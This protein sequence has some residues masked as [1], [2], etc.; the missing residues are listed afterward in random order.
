M[1]E[2]QLNR[3]LKGEIQKTLCLAP[4][5][6][7][8]CCFLIFFL[9]FSS[10]FFYYSAFS[11]N[12]HFLFSFITPTFEYMLLYIDSMPIQILFWG[13]CPLLIA[14]KLSLISLPRLQ[15]LCLSQ[16]GGGTGL[17]SK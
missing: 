2:M 5:K 6:L 16:S 9:F 1:N 3:Q 11:I 13:L 15:L 17:G 12:S 4:Q 10:K 7:K 14:L 8:C